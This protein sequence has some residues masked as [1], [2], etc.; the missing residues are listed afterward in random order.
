M[1][2]TTGYNSQNSQSQTGPWNVQAPFMEAIYNRSQDLFNTSPPAYFPGSTYAGPNAWQTGGAQGLIDYAQQM[3]GNNQWANNAQQFSNA[4][5]QGAVTGIGGLSNIG[6]GGMLGRNPFIDQMFDRGAERITK[7]FNEAAIPGLDAKF[8]GTGMGGGSAH[9][10]ATGA[11]ADALGGS[12]ADFG[13]NLFGNAYNQDAGRQVQ[14]LQSLGQTGL[15][16]Q[17]LAPNLQKLGYMPHVYQQQAGDYLQGF[18]QAQLDADVARHNYDT[19]GGAADWLTQWSNII[20]GHP[21]QTS[22]T[23]TG[24]SG[25]NLGVN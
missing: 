24:G 3:S 11:T 25:F 16:A 1:P 21:V 23:E 6:S 10:L 17:S 18:D 19:G 8:A 15:G 4:A 2:L 22:Q 14:A 9:A 7:H 13:A 5:T 20:L 12:L